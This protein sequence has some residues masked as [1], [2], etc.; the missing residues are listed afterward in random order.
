[1]Q[2]LQKEPSK[3]LGNGVNGS[4]D[5]KQHKWFKVINWKKLEAREVQPKFRP[6]VTGQDCIANFDERWTKMP[7]HDSPASTPKED[8]MG[9]FEGYTYV[10]PNT[11]LTLIEKANIK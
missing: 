7:A 1:M 3:R 10:A 6:E 4:D 5:I 11:W 2:L 8:G 9:L